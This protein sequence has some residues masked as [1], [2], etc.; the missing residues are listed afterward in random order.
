MRVL[1]AGAGAL[2]SVFGA[3]LGRAGDDVT[4]LGRAAHLEAIA[5]DG[6]R[7]DGLWGEHLVRGLATATDAAALRGVF[8]AILLPVKSYD[9]AAVSEA[10]AP[11][12]ADDGVVISLQN[13]LGNVETVERIVGAPRVL[14]ARVIFGA[15][16]AAPGHVRVT[17]FADPTAI[18][19]LAPGRHP[20]RDRAAR[21]WA[22]R[23]DAAGVPAIYTETL[24][25]LLW[26]KVFYNA[27][28]NPLGALLDLHYGALPEH[29]SSRALMDAVID[30]AFAV[31]RAEGV[32]LAWPDAAA[33]RDELYGRLV[34]ATYHHR[35]S[36]LQDLS[37]GRRTE[38]DAINGAVWER[39]AAVAVETPINAALT[40]LLRIAA[41]KGAT[42]GRS[43]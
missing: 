27:A 17:V 42:R 10:V 16:I 20:G 43:S 8:D 1:I 29:P 28:L 36:M 5:R 2:G 4:L 34:P 21:A 26:A 41:A 37:H 6:L 9:T 19:A 7:V 35:S 38:I 14:G 15:T 22:A 32:A 18:G 33:Y 23:I 40:R 30:E 11:R 13:G 3:F 12:L 39:G 24:P 25:A 31:A